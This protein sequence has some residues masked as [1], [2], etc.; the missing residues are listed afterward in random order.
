MLAPKL[1]A[2][3]SVLSPGGAATGL[4]AKSKQTAVPVGGVPLSPATVEHTE[5]AVPAGL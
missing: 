5:V 1:L 3:R 4:P 2:A